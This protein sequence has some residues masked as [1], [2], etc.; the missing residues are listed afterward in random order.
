ML[1]AF[2]VERRA[3]GG[4]AAEEAAS[5]RVGEVP[6]EIAYALESEHRIEDVERNHLDPVIRVGCSGRGERTHRA[7]FGDAFF[8]DLAVLRLLVVEEHVG[9]VRL[10]ELPLAGVD[11]HLAE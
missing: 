2:A 3:S 9:V 7:G 6:Y 1:Q 10:V 5:A 11:A 4:R 8:E